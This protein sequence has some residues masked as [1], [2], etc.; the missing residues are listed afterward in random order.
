MTEAVEVNFDGLV[1]LTHNFGGLSHGNIASATNKNQI[2][3][4]KPVSYTHLD[5]YKRQDGDLECLLHLMLRKA[6][7]RANAKTS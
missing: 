3:S 4:P 6:F 7:W 1:G 5:V 2:S